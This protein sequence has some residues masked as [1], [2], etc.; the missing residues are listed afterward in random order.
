MTNL[1]TPTRCIARARELYPGRNS[2]VTRKT[3]IGLLTAVSVLCCVGVFIGARMSS[4]PH[5]S[6]EAAKPALAS[7][8]PPNPIPAQE[9][10]PGPGQP[11]ALAVGSA[12]CP[13]SR[14]RNQACPR[15]SGV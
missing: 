13:R 9:V 14:A 11:A 3:Q 7:N 15:E 4:G 8:A 10:T 12:D 6:T 1:R 2:K 5:A